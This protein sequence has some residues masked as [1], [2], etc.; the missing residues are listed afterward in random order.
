MNNAFPADR[1]IIITGFMGTGKTTIGR[2]LAERLQRTFVDMDEQIEANFGKPIPQIFADE[3]EPAFRVAEAQLC[4]HFAQERG[5]VVSTGGGAS[6]N[7]GNRHMLAETG[8]LICLTA[9]IDTILDRVEQAEH[10][11]LLPGDRTERSRRIRELLD[12]RRH[13]YAAIPH[14]VSTSGLSPEQVVDRLLGGAFRRVRSRRYDPHPRARA[15]GSYDICLGEG[16]IRHA[17]SLFANR[18]LRP[19]P[20]AIVSNQA[21]ADQIAEVWY[22]ASGCRLC[23]DAL[24]SARRRRTQDP[25]DDPVNLRPTARRGAGPAQSHRCLGRGVIGD[26]TG[27]AAAT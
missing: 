19:G 20:V 10:R 17:G 27:F 9:S 2:L 4:Q 6:V 12:A 15:W 22:K 16:L 26:M 24:P 13:A 7:P 14:Q 18:S 23:A 25:G 11:P 3:G 8:V 1:N 5:I 21:I